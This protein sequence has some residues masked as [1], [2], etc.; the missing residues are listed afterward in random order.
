M[1]QLHVLSG[2]LNYEFRMQVRRLSVWI[3]F[4]ALGLFLHN[5]ISPG[6]D[7]SRR[8]WEML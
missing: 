5:F 4:I 8:Q 2:A 7:P 1:N 3:T 6:I